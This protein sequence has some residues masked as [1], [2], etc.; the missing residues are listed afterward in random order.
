[1]ESL[2]ETVTQ[3]KYNSKYGGHNPALL[4]TE[5]FAALYEGGRYE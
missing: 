2:Y 5:A 3:P 4:R 1:M